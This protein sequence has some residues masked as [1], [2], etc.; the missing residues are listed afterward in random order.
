MP[1]AEAPADSSPETA[2]ARRT[3]IEAP[4][5]S[6]T[7]ENRKHTV[8]ILLLSAL[9]FV[10]A[11]RFELQRT[12]ADEELYLQLGQQIVE[13]GFETLAY[14][15]RTYLYPL[16]LAIPIRLL[17]DAERVW[18]AVALTQYLLLVGSALWLT[19]YCRNR[20]H[21]SPLAGEIAL[22][23]IVLNP[24]L[25]FASHRVLTDVPS[26]CLG[27]VGL[28]LAASSEWAK[29]YRIGLGF[30]LMSAAT[31]LRPSASIFLAVA[32]L[33][34]LCRLFAERPSWKKVVCAGA[35]SAVLTGAIFAPQVRM[36]YVHF[37]VKSPLVAGDLYSLH[38]KNA[39]RFLR[40]ETV[41]IHGHVPGRFTLNPIPVEKDKSDSIYEALYEQPLAA[42]V[43]L[44]G[45]AFSLIEWG[46]PQ[47]YIGCL[48]CWLGRVLSVAA[49]SVAWSLA[50]LGLWVIQRRRQW[51]S[52]SRTSAAA[53]VV[54]ICALSTSVVEGRFGF[55]LLLLATPFIAAGVNQLLLNQPLR[56]IGFA[57]C[58]LAV[59][60]ALLGTSFALDSLAATAVMWR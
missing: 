1:Q 34:L 60:A 43:A 7:H 17:G 13:Y 6:G 15:L 58:W 36:N 9:A 22:A 44:G 8:L 48:D 26:A 5:L 46:R 50:G 23:C 49:Q 10:L 57:A 31:M 55:P 14:P 28:V 53:A 16:M 35:V 20:L 30:A 39:I 11:E 42:V 41:L 25:L 2:R 29:W 32:A 45:H 37:H 52:L 12:F 51:T 54:Y 21:L 3:P 19:R 4:Q 33:A 24:Y 47:V 18:S 56:R 40:Y 38:A 59:F 27:V